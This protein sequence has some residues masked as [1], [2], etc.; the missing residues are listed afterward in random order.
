[1]ARR[2]LGDL[3]AN[4]DVLEEAEELLEET[5]QTLKKINN[6]VKSRRSH[7]LG[8]MTKTLAYIKT[9]SRRNV[10]KIMKKRKFWQKHRVQ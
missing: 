10:D 5:T 2:R 7:N 3:E 6:W 1:M 9:F 4:G 8:I